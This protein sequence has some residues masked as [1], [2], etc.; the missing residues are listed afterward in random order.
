MDN[1]EGVA[2][3]A[4]AIM[5]RM[6]LLDAENQTDRREMREI[7]TKLHRIIEFTKTNNS[8][9]WSQTVASGY[10]S[11]A[12]FHLRMGMRFGYTEWKDSLHTAK[13][14]YNLAMEIYRTET[15]DLN[16]S[17]SSIEKMI[18]IIDARLSG[19]ERN[20]VNK[21]SDIKIERSKFKFYL[22][23]LGRN[24]ITTINAGLL[25][26]QTLFDF[27]YTVNAERLVTKLYGRSQRAH[28]VDHNCTMDAFRLLTR[29]RE[30]RVCVKSR[31]GETFQALRYVESNNTDND[32]DQIQKLVLQGPIAIPRN[33][34]KEQTMQQDCANISYVYGTPVIFCLPSIPRL[35]DKVG[36]VMEFDD[37]TNTYSVY[38][39]VE[40]NKVG[41]RAKKV[42]QRH[43]RIAFDLPEDAE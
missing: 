38:C 30:R 5:N 32:D 10:M 37:E 15:D 42:E 23:N 6:T 41:M 2:M 3:H 43:L 28:G 35:H 40:E 24:H 25:Y 20:V 27:C 34:S 33:V 21:E 8:R 12:T 4:G 39:E 9:R 29:V 31:P 1:A 17:V 19:I 13:E 14:Y 26:S 11:I 16:L 36:S 22:D 18:A 7:C